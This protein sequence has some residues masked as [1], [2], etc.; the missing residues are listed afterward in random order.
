L[1][2]A[3]LEQLVEPVALDELL[4]EVQLLHAEAAADP[5]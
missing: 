3:Q 2:A 4:P 5:A 1:P